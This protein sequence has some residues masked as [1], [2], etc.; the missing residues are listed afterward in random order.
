MF[1]IVCEAITIRYVTNKLANNF[2]R[3]TGIKPHKCI[4][5]MFTSNKQTYLFTIQ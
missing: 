4:K 1:I 2:Y 5:I 3:T